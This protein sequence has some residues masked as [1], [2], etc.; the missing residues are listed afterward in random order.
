[1]GEWAKPR[2]PYR[3][4]KGHVRGNTRQPTASFVDSEPAPWRQRDNS[5]RVSGSPQKLQLSG[6]RAT[7]LS[8]LASRAM[9]GSVFTREVLYKQAPGLVIC[10]SV[11]CFQFNTMCL[12]A[13]Q[14]AQWHKA[15]IPMCIRTNEM[16]LEACVFDSA[17]LSKRRDGGRDYVCPANRSV[18]RCGPLYHGSR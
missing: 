14:M 11:C 13:A 10:S 1:V 18:S 15:V 6:S 12:G 8:I 17:Y 9:F 16:S 4:S 5:S 3:S 7:T 2:D